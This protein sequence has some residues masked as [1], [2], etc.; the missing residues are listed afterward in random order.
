MGRGLSSSLFPSHRPLCAFS[1]PQ[2]PY[3]TKMAFC[4][5]ESFHAQITLATLAFG[6]FLPGW[7]I[8]PSV[9]LVLHSVQLGR[10]YFLCGMIR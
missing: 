3:D 2:V 6:G 10:G 4:R 5:G 7:I 1:S 8:P 9:C